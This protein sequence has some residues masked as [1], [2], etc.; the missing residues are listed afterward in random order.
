MKKNKNVDTGKINIG[1]I[2]HVLTANSIGSCIAIALFDFHKHIGGLAHIMLPGKA[3]ESSEK[4][5]LRYAADAIE[6]LVILMKDADARKVN[7]RACIAGGGNVLKR[8]DDTICKANIRSVKQ[9]LN[10]KN[11][12]ITASSLGGDTRRTLKFDIEK[13]KVFCTE[14]DSKRHPLCK[15][16]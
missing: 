9:I 6:E 4:E 11:I 14:G 10:D 15:F 5:R 16:I 8:P 12:L 3:P 2:S 1:D 13:G 7:I